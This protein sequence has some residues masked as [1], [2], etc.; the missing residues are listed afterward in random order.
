MG[1]SGVYGR[2]AE[3]STTG[4]VWEIADELARRRGS[5]PK[6]REV[7]AAFGREGGNERTALTQ[8]SH[9]KKAYLARQGA[10]ADQGAR[11]AHWQVEG[12]GRLVIPPDFL[13]AMQVGDDGRVMARLEDGELRLI[14]PRTALKRL[15]Q[16]ARELAPGGEAVVGEFIAEKRREAE[17]E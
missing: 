17:L 4:R 7:A 3:G 8:Y 12:G 5:L 1:V 11:T 9:W 6:G 13:A 2:P 14:T 16:V 10:E 15:R